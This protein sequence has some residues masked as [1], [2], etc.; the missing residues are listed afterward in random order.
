MQPLRQRLNGVHRWAGVVF[1]GLLYAVFWM[2]TL[3][4]F[5]REI[6]RWMMPATRLAAPTA[7][8]ALDRIAQAVAP[9]VPPGARQWRIDLATDRTPVLRFSAQPAKCAAVSRRLD[10]ASLAPLPE[11]GTLG[12][13]GFFYPFHYGLQI[14]WL[15]LGKWLVGA[16]AMALLLLLVSGVVVHRKLFAEFFTFR[17]GKRLARSSLDLHNVSGVVGLPFFF[18]I[19]LSGLAIFFGMYFPGAYQS[20]FEAGARGKAQFQAEA[21]G[22]YSRPRAGTPAPPAASLDAMA[23]EADRL[24][25]G[26]A[27]YFVR[28]WLPG[29]ANSYVE[30]RRSYAGEVTMNLDQLYF[31]AAT[32][33]LLR[34]FEAAPVMRVQRFLSG[35]HFVQFRHWPLRW[36]YFL[37]GLGGCVMIGAGMVFWLESRPARQPV[38]DHAGRRV[39]QA[40]CIGSV[41]GIVV[42]TLAFLAGNRLLP[43]D[44]GLAG[45]GRAELEVWCFFLAWI[46]CFGHAGWRGAAAWRDQLWVVAVLALSCVAL[47]ALTTDAYRAGPAPALAAVWGVD[48]ALLLL[49]LLAAVL[50][51]RMGRR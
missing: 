12:A 14:A 29:D 3:S 40:V 5:D 11:P 30:L 2:G 17:P 51:R 41:A 44:A 25:G 10:P 32:G 9:L 34:R 36:L 28:V 24:W 6:D 23:A 48:L 46:S 7:E 33:R 39:V 22:R 45:W 42:A 27:P 13:S 26:G 21:Y 37:L 19:A 4:V 47:N 1:A 35:L 43:A 16:A 50:A 49:A 8:P 20:A 31:D 15:D 18:M 38:H